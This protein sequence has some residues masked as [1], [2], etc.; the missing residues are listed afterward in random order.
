M[1]LPSS[2]QPPPIK[3]GT[4]RIRGRVQSS[5]TGTPIRRAVLRLT[6]AEGDF[7]NTTSDGEGR[8]EFRGLPAGRFRLSADKSGYVPA[9]YGQSRPSG[10]GKA[11]DL[12]DGDALDKADIV[13]TRGSAI[14][15]RVLD[16]F[17]DPVID[18]TVT[19]MRSAWVN[20]RR[21][22]TGVGRAVTSNDLGQFRLFGLTAGD[23]YVSATVRDSAMMGVGMSVTAAPAGVAAMSHITAPT[24]GY[25]P[26]YFPG[27]ASVAEAQKITLGPGQDAPNTDFALIPTRLARITGTVIN[28]A[29]K[30]VEGTI[31]DAAPRSGDLAFGPDAGRSAP[32]APDG[33]FMLGSVP[34]GDYLLQTQPLLIKTTGS[35][36]M[37]TFTARLGGGD[38]ETGS[39]PL[40]ISGEDVSN[41]VIVTSKGATL[42][43]KVTFD[44]APKPASLPPIHIAA[45][46]FGAHDDAFHGSPAPV[47]ADGA[48]S[49]RGLS[50]S[51]LIR[52]QWLPEG[53]VLKS[54]RANGVDVTDAGID[55][56]HGE[57]HTGVEV[58]L[59]S[60]V[61]RLS[62]S[63]TGPAG[64]PINDYSLVL[65]SEDPERWTLPD[66]RYVTR[67]QPT[68]ADGRF[69]VSGLPEGVY[70]VAVSD[71]VPEDDWTA[72]DPEVLEQLRTTARKV[73]LKE[74]TTRTLE[75]KLPERR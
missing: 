63:V 52:P 45:Q 22:V 32:T 20:G 29:G 14:T 74:G 4:A 44:G 49:L 51:R 59:T 34:P 75:L 15:G 61:T 13:M 10:A 67:A 16:E 50:G 8:F 43:G 68:A 42:T 24:T 71:D 57:T 39:L 46:P 12:A 17:G 18:A 21:R 73:T 47:G 65:F 56:R 6:G 33:T 11:I 9:K 3:T 41:V 55:F 72:R 31:V 1:A 62:G 27:T 7:R 64:T 53:W 26:T 28:A 30:P 19:A 40:T 37:M 54:V 48:F 60:K 23:Y 38:A 58:A 66:G 36:D 25:A 69:E 2:G 70:Y 35:G 5:D